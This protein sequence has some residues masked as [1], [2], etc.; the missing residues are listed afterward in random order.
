MSS[1]PQNQTYFY[2]GVDH[3]PAIIILAFLLIIA[4]TA[5]GLVMMATAH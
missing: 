2:I 3:G 5:I 4:I 1:K